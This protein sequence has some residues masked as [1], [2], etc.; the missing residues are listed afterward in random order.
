MKTETM[1]VDSRGTQIGWSVSGVFFAT[2]E[3][4]PI[5]DPLPVFNTTK[6]LIINEG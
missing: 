5:T 6:G 2:L 4:C 1:I 3:E